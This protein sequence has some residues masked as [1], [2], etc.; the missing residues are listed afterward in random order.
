[1][2]GSIAEESPPHG[3][4]FVTRA[5]GRTVF[6]DGHPSPIAVVLASALENNVALMADY[7]A[8][9]DVRLAP[10]SK[11]ALSPEVARLQ[12]SSGAWGLTAANAWQ[13]SRLREWQTERILL[14]SIVADGSGLQ[15]IA[16]VL[17]DGD[18]QT[19][20]YVFVDSI[21]S[22]DLLHRALPRHRP[23]KVLLEVGYDG[24]RCGVRSPDNARKLAALIASHDCCRLVGLATFEGLIG[25]ARS[26]GVVQ[27]VGRLAG[28]IM[29]LARELFAAGLLPA[30]RIVSAGGSAFFD[31]IVDA[32][33][34][35]GLRDE[36]FELVLRSGGYLFHDHGLYR[37]VSPLD[38]PD[39]GPPRLRP[40][41]EVWTTVVSRPEPALAICDFGR[42]DAGTDA[43]LPIVVSR[44]HANGE[45]AALADGIRISHLND[46]H[47]FVH[48]PPNAPLLVGDRLGMGIKHPCSTLD[49][50]RAMPLVNDEYQ[51]QDHLDIEL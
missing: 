31:L 24:G 17:A 48:V 8:R 9:R 2:S 4:R 44:R 37:G 10:H 43:G 23:L 39:A 28:G 30:E 1:M 3:R 51:V 33:D 11:T 47:G 13:A 42:R 29:E 32:F 50:W 18:R 15:W 14:A 45:P 49:R 6:T 38:L 27:E 40:A 35:A 19:D 21:E 34:S 12:I 41:L 36:G 26:A 22:V 5:A 16:D 46:H 25:P 20:L 7:C